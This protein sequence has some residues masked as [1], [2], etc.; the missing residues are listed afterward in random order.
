[1]LRALVK[2]NRRQEQLGN[3]KREME[4]IGKNRKKMPEIKKKTVTEMKNAFDGSISRLHMAKGRISEL[5]YK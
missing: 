3:I 4:N 2:S 5:G 1:M